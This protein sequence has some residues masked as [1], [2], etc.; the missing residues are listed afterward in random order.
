MEGTMFILIIVA[1]VILWIL[2]GVQ[3][4][5]YGKKQGVVFMFKHLGICTALGVVLFFVIVYPTI[6]CTGWLCG[7]GEILIFLGI[8]LLTFLI[9]PII[10]LIVASRKYRSTYRAKENETI[11][12]FL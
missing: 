5:K 6:N 3:L 9:W 4:H 12:D 2:S 8:N 7:L 10:L 1:I 11:D